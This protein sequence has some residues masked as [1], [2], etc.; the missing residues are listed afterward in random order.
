MQNSATPSLYKSAR[1]AYLVL[2]LRKRG[3][4]RPRKMEFDTAALAKTLGVT[5]RSI[6]RDL[7]FAGQVND[8]L[9]TCLKKR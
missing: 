4:G 9:T 6:Q 8:L 7:H 2:M 3:L 1:I 5:Q